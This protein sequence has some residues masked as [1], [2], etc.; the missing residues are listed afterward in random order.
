[1]VHF[2]KN[3]ASLPQQEKKKKKLNGAEE[4]RIR[5]AISFFVEK[6]S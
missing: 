5:L 2:L 6:H 4:K 3:L 1:M